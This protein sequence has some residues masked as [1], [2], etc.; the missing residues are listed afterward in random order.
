MSVKKALF[1]ALAIVILTGC[2]RQYISI[3]DAMGAGFAHTEGKVA[4]LFVHGPGEGTVAQWTFTPPA[5][6]EEEKARQLITGELKSAGIEINFS[7][8]LV[9]NLD[10]KQPSGATT[11]D[12]WILDGYCR[13]F[14]VG[15]E[16][17]AK[18]DFHMLMKPHSGLAFREDYYMLGAAEAVRSKFLNYGRIILGVFYDP[19][20]PA[21]MYLEWTREKPESVNSLTNDYITKQL[22]LQVQDFID[23]LYQEGYLDPEG[24]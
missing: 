23:W 13:G 11:G 4:P 2:S 21:D 10:Q 8:V 16:F 5:F 6:F 14:N 17:V 22:R 7:D 20:V 15:F 19:L 18:A 24:R 12:T 9:D 3:D 1:F